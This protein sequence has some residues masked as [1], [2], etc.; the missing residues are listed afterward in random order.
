MEEVT[1]R[2][3]DRM[4]CGAYAERG[5]VG[6]DVSPEQVEIPQQKCYVKTHN[7]KMNTDKEIKPG[8]IK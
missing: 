7:T 4:G 2:V 5:C 3:L 8:K 1:C 6:A